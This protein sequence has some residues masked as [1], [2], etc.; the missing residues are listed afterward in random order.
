MRPF[1]LHT[2]DETEVPLVPNGHG[3]PAA[4][5][6]DNEEVGP[7]QVLDQMAGPSRVA[8]LSD[9]AGDQEFPGRLM[10][11][12]RRGRLCECLLL[13]A[14]RSTMAPVALEADR[15]RPFY[16]VHGPQP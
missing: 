11:A 15:Q 14:F 7:G 10:T 4:R 8:L 9:R 5:L 16:R 1:A 6:S 12:P 13:V 2:D 3:I